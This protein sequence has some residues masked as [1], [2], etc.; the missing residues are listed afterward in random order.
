MQHRPGLSSVKFI[1][2]FNSER[3]DI[4]TQIEIFFTVGETHFDIMI[5]VLGHKEGV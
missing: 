2:L 5:C 1:F 4:C 3:P